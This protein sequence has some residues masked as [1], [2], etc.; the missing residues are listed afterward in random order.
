MS[1]GSKVIISW[2]GMGNSI[3]RYNGLLPGALFGED[4]KDKLS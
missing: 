1:G 2:D 3:P 4:L